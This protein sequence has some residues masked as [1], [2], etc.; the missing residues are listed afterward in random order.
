[1]K[2]ELKM[3]RIKRRGFQIWAIALAIVLGSVLAVM[4][5]VAEDMEPAVAPP[6]MLKFVGKNLIMKAKGTFHDWRVVE[7]SVDLDALG[8][9]F[10]VVEV[11]LASLDT[12]IEGR[13]DHLRNPDFFEVDTYP[14]AFVRVH[15]P[16][17]IAGETNET[18]EQPRFAVQFDVN[19]HGVEKTVGGEIVLINADPIV[20]EG[21]LVIDR[22]EFGVGPEPGFWSPMVPKAEIPVRFRVEL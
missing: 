19:L 17:P 22:M 13:D 14:V 11:Q 6:G 18:E 16:E 1:M 9:A 12:G 5:I 7:S 15:S 4:P 10:A 8:E 3:I 20:I 2:G 21:E